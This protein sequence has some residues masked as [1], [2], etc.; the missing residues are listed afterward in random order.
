MDSRSVG[1]LVVGFGI[2]AILMGLLILTGALHWFGRL[3]GDI[4]IEGEHTRVYVPIASM[5]LVSLVLSLLGYLVS[6]LVH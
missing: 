6:R 2:A 4:R 1:W 5:I 3:P